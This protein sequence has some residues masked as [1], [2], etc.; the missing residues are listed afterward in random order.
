MAGGFIENL[1]R[2]AAGDQPPVAIRPAISPEMIPDTF[3]SGVSIPPMVPAVRGPEPSVPAPVLRTGEKASAP[4]AKS[5]PEPAREN[6]V[7]SPETRIEARLPPSGAPA[8]VRHTGAVPQAKPPAKI[9]EHEQEPANS[10]PSA[11]THVGAADAHRDGH[12]KPGPPEPAHP[13][14]PAKK[15]PR[16]TLQEDKPSA[17]VAQAPKPVPQTGGFAE[18]PKAKSAKNGTSVK[19]SAKGAVAI[20]PDAKSVEER[21]SAITAPGAPDTGFIQQGRAAA[22]PAKH[23]QVQAYRQE[24]T[25]T[26]NIGRIEVRAVFPQKQAPQTKEQNGISLS[27]YLKLRAERKL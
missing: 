24:D 3:S 25:V 13:G 4:A 12:D 7:I 23:M 22:R 21:A 27:E 8:E 18:Q 6:N 17:I 5:S 2:R 15:T 10:P 1:A 14:G 20:R 16:E 11:K 19:P 26:I 9:K